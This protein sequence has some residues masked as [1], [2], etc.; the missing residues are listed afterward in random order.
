[1]IRRG[2]PEENDGEGQNPGD[3]GVRDYDDATDQSGKRHAPR[4]GN[5]DGR[6]HI[7]EGPWDGGSGGTGT[8][9]IGG[10]AGPYRLDVG[11]EL[12][13][14]SEEQK[15]EVSEAQKGRAMS[16]VRGLAQEGAADGG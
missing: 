1:M 10:R 11:Q 4:A 16:S 13:L 2:S 9:G 5:W 12:V 7:G 14:L 8:A 3:V 15:K 6:Q